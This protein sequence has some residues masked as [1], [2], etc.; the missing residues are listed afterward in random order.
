LTDTG[1]L[2]C[3]TTSISTI[4]RNGAAQECPICYWIRLSLSKYVSQ[5]DRSRIL[6]LVYI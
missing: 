4:N 6:Y 5:Y 2:N 1:W 3:L